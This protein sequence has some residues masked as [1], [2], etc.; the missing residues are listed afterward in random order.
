MSSQKTKWIFIVVITISAV[1]KTAGYAQKINWGGVIKGGK[2]YEPAIIGEDSTSYYIY[3]CS[4]KEL[5]IEK[6]EKTSLKTVYSKKYDVLKNHQLEKVVLTDTKILFFFSN[7][8]KD[9]KKTMLYCN[10]YLSKDGTKAESMNT[11][12]SANLESEERSAGIRHGVKG[13]YENESYKIITTTDNE[14][15][16]IL[17]EMYSEKEKKHTRNYLL[18]NTDLKKII[19]KKEEISRDEDKTF[20][21][22]GMTL[23]NAGSLYFF[24]NYIGTANYKTSLICY[25]A[26]KAYESYEYIIDTTKLN[27]P[28]NG[29]LFNSAITFDKEGNMLVVGEY[30][31]NRL[32]AGYFFIK[33]NTKTKQMVH[34][35]INEFDENFT[36]QFRTTRQIKKGK[37]GVIPRTFSTMKLIVKEDG[38]IIGT[39]QWYTW[40]ELTKRVKQGSIMTVQHVGEYYIYKDIIAINLSADGKMLWANRIP[41]NQI[42]KYKYIN[43]IGRDLVYFSH[44][45]AL[46]NDKLFIAYNDK[47]SNVSI[48]NDKLKRFKHPKGSVLALFTID[49]ATGEK[50]KSQFAD[51]MDTET[52]PEPKSAFQKSQNSYMILI[53]SSGKKFKNGVMSFGK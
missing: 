2:G 37:N 36:N 1:I 46:S 15:I 39:T 13:V 35:R 5:I 21:T 23:D 24:K 48:T 9:K 53:G 7:Y 20:D 43:N 16:L 30:I 52:K 29:E 27:V 25:D 28:S 45:V 31:K 42:L 49:L 14:K 32:P 44:F 50:N 4:Q 17:H 19:E 8:E 34:G 11:L 10:A 51:G 41:R 26:N 6:H 22:D 18:F 38:G 47:P 12:F 3:S 33:M 40:G